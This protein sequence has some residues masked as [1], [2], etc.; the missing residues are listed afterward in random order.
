MPLQRE[1]HSVKRLPPGADLGGS[2][3]HRN[4][5]SFATKHVK[6]ICDQKLYEMG[7]EDGS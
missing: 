4:N 5:V 1:G 3:E 6:D 7:Q 2:R